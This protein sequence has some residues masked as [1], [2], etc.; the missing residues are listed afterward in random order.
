MA[1][2]V[3]QRSGE[4]FIMRKEFRQGSES[5]FGSGCRPCEIIPRSQAGP[6]RRALQGLLGPAKNTPTASP[7]SPALGTRRPWLSAFLTRKKKTAQ[8]P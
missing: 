5:G 6:E 7:R 3:G 2:S 4:Q 8:S 1:P